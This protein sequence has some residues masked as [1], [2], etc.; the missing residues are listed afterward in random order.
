M[1]SQTQKNSSR[2]QDVDGQV[3]LFPVTEPEAVN[4][5]REVIQPNYNESA[6][7]N[8]NG[9][10]NA[11]QILTEILYCIPVVDLPGSAVIIFLA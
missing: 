3:I 9:G 5:C 10:E 7:S 11:R 6:N 4:S 1:A 2:L 8:R